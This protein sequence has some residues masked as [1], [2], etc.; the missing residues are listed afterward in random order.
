MSGAVSITAPG[1][2]CSTCCPTPSV[3]FTASGPSIVAAEAEQSRQAVIRFL[4][5][6]Q[7]AYDIPPQNTVIAGFSQGGILSASVALSD[8]E[9]EPHI[10]S[11]ERLST[12]RGFIAHGEYD[13]KLGVAHVIRLYPMEH[14]ISAATKTDF[15]QWIRELTPIEANIRP[16]YSAIRS[17][18]PEGQP[19]K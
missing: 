4:A 11:K 1:C 15:L 6:L 16:R 5:Q 18:V 9:L 14:E 3:A 19:I 8:P 10:A 7:S 13:S 12:L 2:R 17:G